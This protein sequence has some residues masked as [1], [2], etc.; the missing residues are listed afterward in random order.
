VGGPLADAQ[1]RKAVRG[2]KGAAVVEE[3]VGPTAKKP[4]KKRSLFKRVTK[5]S[6]FWPVVMVLF[7]VALVI[8]WWRSRAKAQAELA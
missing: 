8:Y 7:I 3:V 2:K 5:H 1:Q 6:Y 4:M